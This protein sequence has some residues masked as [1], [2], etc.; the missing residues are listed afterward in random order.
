[1]LLGINREIQLKT[2]DV[3]HSNT[4]SLIQKN[5]K[6]N[7]FPQLFFTQR[8]I[9]FMTKKTPWLVK[10]LKYSYQNSLTWALP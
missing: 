6:K 9:V 4:H 8:E 1:M 3:S 2:E 5:R 10:E 7:S